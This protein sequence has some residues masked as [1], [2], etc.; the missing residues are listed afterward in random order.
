MDKRTIEAIIKAHGYSISPYRGGFKTRVPDPTKADGR[1][2]LTGPTK[3]DIY[4]QLIDW[5]SLSSLNDDLTLNGLYQLWLVHRRE[6]QT[7]SGTIRRNE[8]HFMRYLRTDFFERKVTQINRP[9]LKEFCHSVI[10]GETVVHSG[11]AP[12]VKSA[13]TRKEWTNVSGIL[14]GMFTYALDTGIRK[15]NPIAGMRF[16]KTLFAQPKD[17]TKESEVFNKSEAKQLRDWCFTQYG[18]EK[19]SALL[20]P[21]LILEMGARIGECVALRWEDWYET[22][23]LY[24]H[25]KEHKDKVTNVISLHDYNKMGKKRRICLSR[26]AVEILEMLRANRTGNSPWIFEREGERVTERQGSYVFEKYAKENGLKTKFSHKARKTCGS[27]LLAKGFTI[28]QAADYLGDTVAVFLKH[29][30]YDV[31]TDQDFL[32]RLNADEDPE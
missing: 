17:H 12:Y 6:L 14:N 30:C 28:K 16:Q 15:D 18:Q 8:N 9:E 21:A 10:R 7:D 13:L 5:Y 20:I 32:K 26:K 2:T 3:E 1:R 29:Y 11:K 25:R 27:N 24:I 19:D 31:D 4:L 23:H 22:E